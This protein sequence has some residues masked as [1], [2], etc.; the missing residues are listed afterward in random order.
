M[1]IVVGR[2]ADLHPRLLLPVLPSSSYSLEAE[3][4]QGRGAVMLGSVPNASPYPGPL[5]ATQTLQVQLDA[6]REQVERAVAA[7][8]QYQERQAAVEEELEGVRRQY[9]ATWA[10]I[11]AEKQQ[12]A[13]MWV[14]MSV[15]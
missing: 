11:E 3:G 13:R 4:G 5:P 9:E 7:I 1:G 12:D 2:K 14:A 8:M 15:A 6:T 10:R